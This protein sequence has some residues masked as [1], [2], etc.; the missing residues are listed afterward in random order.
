MLF[1]SDGVRDSMLQR[2][3]I[4]KSLERPQ[5]LE[6]SLG[7]PPLFNFLDDVERDCEAKNALH[8]L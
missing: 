1:T 5:F 3:R 4:K 6:T 7:Q 8:A 2:V